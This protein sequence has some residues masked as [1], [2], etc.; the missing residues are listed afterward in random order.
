MGKFPDKLAFM[1]PHDRFSTGFQSAK[2]TDEAVQHI[3]D[4]VSKLQPGDRL[5]VRPIQD[6]ARKKMKGY[7]DNAPVSAIEVDVAYEEPEYDPD[8]AEIDAEAHQSSFDF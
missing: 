1:F 7:P 2:L 4:V 8:K 6:T 3:K 5:V